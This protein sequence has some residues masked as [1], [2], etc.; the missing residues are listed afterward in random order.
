MVRRIRAGHFA[1]GMHRLAWDGRD[2]SRRPVPSGT[3]FA[4]LRS[5]GVHARERIVLVR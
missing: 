1:A 4:T 2:T 5:G 3:Y